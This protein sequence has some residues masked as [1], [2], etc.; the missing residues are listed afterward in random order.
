VRTAL[1][2]VCLAAVAV[3]APV[4]KAVKPKR[5]DAEV[6][7][8]TWE[9]AVNEMNGN[10][11]A[12]AIWTFDPDLTMWS[13]QPG[14]QGQG[15]KWAIKLDPEKSPKEIDIGHLPGIYEFD[16]D[17]IRVIFSYGKARPTG[18]EAQPQGHYVLLRRVP[19]K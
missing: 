2:L 9:T 11:S 18:Y 19:Q 1:A 4:P 14:D 8:G 13:K 10:P 12:K 7:V 6:F 5:A 16:G 3:A 15:S 17:D